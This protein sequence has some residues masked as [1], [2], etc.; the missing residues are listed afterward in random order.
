MLISNPTLVQTHLCAL[1]FWYKR[2][3]LEDTGAKIRNT[4]TFLMKSQCE[5][6]ELMER[7]EVR[8]TKIGL[9]H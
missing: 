4:T 7:N 3:T 5:N 6:F 9:A 2:V 8:L 1:V